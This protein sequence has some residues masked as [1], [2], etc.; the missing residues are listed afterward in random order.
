MNLRIHPGKGPVSAI[1]FKN[2]L[3]SII[4]LL[5]M[6]TAW[7]IDGIFIGRFVGTN[8]IAAINLSYP[9]MSVF[10]GISVMIAIGGSTLAT[11]SKG[12]KEYKEGDTFFSATVLI[13]VL[14]SIFSTSAGLLLKTRLINLLGADITLQGDVSE[15]L[16]IVLYFILP[17]V[18]AYTLDAFIRNSACPGYSLF[19]LIS[20]S[21]LNIVLD[22]WFI[23]VLGLGL[24]GAAYATGISQLFTTLIQAVFF[25]S[26][27][28]IFRFTIPLIPLKNILKILYNGSSELINEMSAGFTSYLFNIVLMKRIGANGV[29]AF[30]IF[31]Y[32]LM[33]ALMIFFAT[34]QSIQP[35]INYCYGSGKPKRIRKM[36]LLGLF[37]NLGAGIFFFTAVFLKADMISHIFTGKATSLDPIVTEIARYFSSAFLLSGINIVTSSYFTSIQKPRESAVIATS[38]GLVFVSLNLM[39]LPLFLGNIGIWLTI[40]VSE[41]LTLLVSFYF[42]YKNNSFS[43]LQETD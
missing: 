11:A 16:T 28:S 20:G 37:F 36:F 31:N 34:A 26:K 40:P 38:R 23:P 18:L 3:T 27:R 24:T 9:L 17:F 33:V 39:I 42:I 13:I 10:F 8:G 4:G 12:K 25:F 15:Y 21:V 19:A 7:I 2:L 5:A 43:P 30:S 32:I 14:F 1:F 22:Y 29:S 35:E 41:M 6:T